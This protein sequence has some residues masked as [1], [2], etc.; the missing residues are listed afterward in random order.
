MRRF[1]QRL[2]ASQKVK[3]W[4][5][6]RVRADHASCAGSHAANG[7]RQHSCWGDVWLCIY[8]LRGEVAFLGVCL[9]LSFS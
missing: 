9:R 7:Q 8:Y 3:K 4:D 1:I 6:Q 2:E 5:I